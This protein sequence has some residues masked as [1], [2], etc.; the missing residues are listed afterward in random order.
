MD[1]GL[2]NDH[3][4]AVTVD[5]DGVIWCSTYG[6]ISSY[7]GTVWKTYGDEHEFANKAVRAIAVDG[8][9]VK[10]FGTY[11]GAASYDGSEWKTYTVDDGLA[12][13]DVRSISVDINGVIWFGT[14]AGVSAFDG[15]FWQSFGV[16]DA[17]GN[18]YVLSIAVDE[19]G[20]KWF[21]TAGGVTRYDGIIASVGKVGSLPLAPT[22]LGNFPNPFNPETHIDF[23]LPHDGFTDLV[24]YNN[25]GQVVR[26][27]LSETL[28]AGHHSV[29]WDGRNNEGSQ[30]SSGIYLFSLK[31]K[32]SVT[33]HKMILMR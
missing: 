27:L 10:W 2:A 33:N 18:R 19:S 7:D 23:I 13:N 4:E 24:I 17:L 26:S 5:K 16:G 11:N 21:G 20:V 15:S 30:V 9:N 31:S 6:G 28:Q 12:G 25:V 1:D 14:T 3:L 32:D 8:N 22:I 29:S